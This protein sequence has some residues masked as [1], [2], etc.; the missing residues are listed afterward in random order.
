MSNE[1][2]NS[3]ETN[4]TV[5]VTRIKRIKGT[6]FITPQFVDPPKDFPKP[7]QLPDK[8]P[9]IVR[10]AAAGHEVGAHTTSHRNFGMESNARFVQ[11][12]FSNVIKR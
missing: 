1:A 11:E 8:W 2:E 6:Y 3:R 12:D 7:A 5:A 9:H 4:C 10:L